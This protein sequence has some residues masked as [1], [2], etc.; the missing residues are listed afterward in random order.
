MA[1]LHDPVPT[2]MPPE[3]QARAQLRSFPEDSLEAWLAYQRWRPAPDGSW[4]VAAARDGWSY[5]IEGAPGGFVR[6]VAWAVGDGCLTSWL[7]E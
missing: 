3:K 4:L 7:I 6:V 5:R 1:T 2:G